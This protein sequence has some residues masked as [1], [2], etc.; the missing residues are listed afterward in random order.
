MKLMKLIFFVV[1]GISSLSAFAEKQDILI[2]NA[3]VIT[4]TDQGVLDETDVL[5]KKGIIS[6]IGKDIN[7]EE[8]IIIN[9]KGRIR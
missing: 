5:I 2:K 6:S 9:A 4:S 7:S 1:I 3:T 8:A